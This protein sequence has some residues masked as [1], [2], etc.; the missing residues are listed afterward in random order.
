MPLLP[1]YLA[2]AKFESIKNILLENNTNKSAHYNYIYSF[3]PVHQSDDVAKEGESA[4]GLDRHKQNQ[5]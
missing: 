3:L 4:A 1:I 5:G 2:V